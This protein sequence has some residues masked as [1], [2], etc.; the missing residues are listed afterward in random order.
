M[1]AAVYT[2]LSVI[3]LTVL[4]P[5]PYSLDKQKFLDGCAKQPLISKYC[6]QYF[7]S[8]GNGFSRKDSLFGKNAHWETKIKEE[9]KKL[10]KTEPSK[11]DQVQIGLQIAKEMNFVAKQQGAIAN[12]DEYWA[13]EYTIFG[14]IMNI[15]IFVAFIG[16]IIGWFMWCCGNKAAEESEDIAD[17]SVTLR[18][19]QWGASTYGATANA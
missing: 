4:T 6:N 7:P 2:I 14:Y 9:W 19:I 12:F 15:F 18:P 17:T 8:D 13:G 5:L 16:I 10:K 3:V 11:W 1:P